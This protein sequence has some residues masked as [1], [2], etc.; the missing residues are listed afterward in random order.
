MANKVYLNSM[1][2]RSL[3]VT[4]WSMDRIAPMSLLQIWMNILYQLFIA[5]AGFGECAES[6]A[7]AGRPERVQRGRNV[8]SE[9][10]PCAARLERLRRA[11]SVCNEVGARAARSERV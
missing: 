9:V 11:R 10:G 5:C 4:L 3:Y 6:G 7:C 8:C 1:M 2:G